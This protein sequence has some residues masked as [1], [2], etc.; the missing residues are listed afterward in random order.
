MTPDQIERAKALLADD[1]QRLGF[2]NVSFMVSIQHDISCMNIWIN[3]MFYARVA[4]ED[5]CERQDAILQPLL[6]PNPDP[7]CRCQV[8]R[9]P[10][11]Y[12]YPSDRCIQHFMELPDE[13]RGVLSARPAT[14]IG[15]HWIMALDQA[16]KAR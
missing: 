4:S 3:D 15:M 6:L 7:A 8:C 13:E 14:S 12:F 1:L 9:V 2:V 16:R 5:D 10:I 11:E